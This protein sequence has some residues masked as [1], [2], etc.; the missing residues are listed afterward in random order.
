MKKYLCIFKLE[1]MSN[2]SYILD[3]V[4]GFIGYFIMLFILLNLWKYI[5]S[6]PNEIINGYSMNQT[7][8]YV[9]ITE[10]L[11][12]VIGGRKFC[13]KIVN[14]VKGGNIAYN[15]NKPYSYVS[16]CLF[17][18]LGD[19][20]IR[21]MVFSILGVLSCF[22]FLGELP[23]LDIISVIL[24]IV[25]SV[26]AIIINTLFILSIGL[27]SF[28]IED[29]SSLYWL[30]SK[31]LLIV[32]TLF[33]IEFFPKVI[34]PFLNY[35]PIFAISYGPAKLFVD[36]SYSN[37]LPVLLSQVFYIITSYLLCRLI[38]KKGVK[39]LNVNGG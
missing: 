10:I 31:V 15:I 14:D 7:I 26:L 29:S 3:N 32:G 17:N 39:N 11:W 6:D 30:Y 5:Y 38:Y 16:Y 28:F 2:L 23:S 34:Q 21:F 36:F 19:C 12:T 35:S 27:I 4:F 18:H 37:L 13:N 22:I 24:T 9:A 20:V 33:P 8:W 25:S 1:L